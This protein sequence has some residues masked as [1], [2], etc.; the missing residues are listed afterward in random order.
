MSRPRAFAR[1]MPL[2][3]VIAS[4]AHS[5]P[6]PPTMFRVF[7]RL[8]DADGNVGGDV[9]V[10]EANRTAALAGAAPDGGGGWVVGAALPGTSRFALGWSEAGRGWLQLFAE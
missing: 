1:V 8:F 5:R 6:A 3:V 7:R 4:A 10:P 9:P 2:L